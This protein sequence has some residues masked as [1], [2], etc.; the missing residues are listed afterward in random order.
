MHHWLNL[1]NRHPDVLSSQKSFFILLVITPLER[2]KGVKHAE[3]LIIKSPYIPTGKLRDRVG[4]G[5]ERSVRK[6]SKVLP[7]TGDDH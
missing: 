7:R 2:Q 3:C 4:D 1:L 5:G 6:R